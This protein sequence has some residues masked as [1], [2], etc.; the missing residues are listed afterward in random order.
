MIRPVSMRST[1]RCGCADWP[2][3]TRT[4]D[5]NDRLRHSFNPVRLGLEFGLASG[6]QVGKDTCLAALRFQGGEVEKL[7]LHILARCRGKFRCKSSCWESS[8]WW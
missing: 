3:D 5:P 6:L 1:A 8:Q 2:E 4:K 7:F